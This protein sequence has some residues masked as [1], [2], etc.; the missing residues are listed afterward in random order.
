[1]FEGA[2]DQL[3]H[4]VHEQLALADRCEERERGDDRLGGD[5]TF[6][7]LR[8]ATCGELAQSPSDVAELCGDRRFGKHGER[9]EGADAELAEP[10]MGIGVE[11]QNGDGLGSEEFLFC[12]C[13]HNNR[14]ARLGAACRG[15]RGELAEAETQT[16]EGWTVGR[17]DGI[18]RFAQSNLPTFQPSLYDFYDFFRRAENPFQ[19]ID[20]DV[21]KSELCWFDDR[22]Y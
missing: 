7:R 1:M 9:P 16:D 17:L 15:P 6:D 11:R 4:R 14:F 21:S 2:R 22:T 3:L 13:R 8:D 19:A 10:A 20:T 12:T 5:T 18:P